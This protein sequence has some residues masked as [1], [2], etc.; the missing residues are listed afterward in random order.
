[1]TAIRVS[2]CEP[3]QDRTASVAKYLVAGQGTVKDYGA[4]AASGQSSVGFAL[5]NDFLR[6]HLSL[7]ADNAPLRDIKKEQEIR[8]GDH[9]ARHLGQPRRSTEAEPLG[10]Y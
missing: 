10:V 8:P 9:W 1:M 3:L 2:P 5:S 4:W 7:P 6:G